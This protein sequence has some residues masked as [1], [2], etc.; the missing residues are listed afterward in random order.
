MCH[1]DL[2]VLSSLYDNNSSLYEVLFSE[3]KTF[4]VISLQCGRMCHYDLDLRAFD[5]IFYRYLSLSFIC[6]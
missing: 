1:Y 4:G 2:E 6:E 3:L 5:P